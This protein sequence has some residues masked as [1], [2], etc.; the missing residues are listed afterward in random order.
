M[1]DTDSPG[2][3]IENKTVPNSSQKFGF[4]DAKNQIFYY[5]DEEILNSFHSVT[6]NSSSIMAL[7]E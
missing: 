5:F 6:D 3:K 4:F 2:N 1:S 7:L